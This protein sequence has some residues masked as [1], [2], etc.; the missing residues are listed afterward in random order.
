MKYVAIV[1]AGHDLSIMRSL[2]CTYLGEKYATP[3]RVDTQTQCLW[4]SAES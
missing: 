4:G 2:H 3:V 1:T